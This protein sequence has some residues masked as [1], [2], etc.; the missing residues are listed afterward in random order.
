MGFTNRVFLF[1]FSDTNVVRGIDFELPVAFWRPMFTKRNM[2]KVDRIAELMN[3]EVFSVVESATP[4]WHT[5]CNVFLSCGTALSDFESDTKSNGEIDH[6][7][8]VF[9]KRIWSDD[10]RIRFVA[11]RDRRISAR[12]PDLSGKRIWNVLG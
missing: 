9:T 10:Y 6:G 2:F 11:G 12:Q 3:P 4:D 8:T 5:A 1:R 7:T